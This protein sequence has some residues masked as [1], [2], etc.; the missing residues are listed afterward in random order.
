MKHNYPDPRPAP[1]PP[2]WWVVIGLVVSLII[3][4][5]L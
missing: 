5:C 3:G 1:A 2:D 4:L